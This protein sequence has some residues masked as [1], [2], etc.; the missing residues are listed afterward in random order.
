MVSEFAHH[1]LSALAR[2]IHL[3]ERLD[4]P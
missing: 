3:I 1:R 2:Y 4:G